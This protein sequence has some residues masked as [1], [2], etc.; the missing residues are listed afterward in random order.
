MMATSR[1]KEPS[2]PTHLMGIPR[3]CIK[4]ILCNVTVVSV[5]KRDGIAELSSINIVDVDS[6]QQY[7]KKIINGYTKTNLTTHA[8]FQ[9]IYKESNTP[10]ILL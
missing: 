7:R 6:V 1:M 5:A 4:T 3:W 9:F 2:P 8:P 10:L